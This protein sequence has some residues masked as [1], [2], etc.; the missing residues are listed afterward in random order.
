M[1]VCLLV[2]ARAWGEGIA[3]SPTHLIPYSD[4]E[5][6]YTLVFATDMQ[7]REDHRPLGVHRR[8]CDLHSRVPKDSAVVLI[9]P[10]W[11]RCSKSGRRNM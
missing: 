6:M 5:A 3:G 10:Q 9:H 1:A 7:L 11:Q 4:K 2:W 8:V